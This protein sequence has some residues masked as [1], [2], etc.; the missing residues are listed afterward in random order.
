MQLRKSDKERMCIKSGFHLNIGFD[1]V[2]HFIANIIWRW[3]FCL[4][5][6]A[7]SI[8]NFVQIWNKNYQSG[9]IFIEKK[10]R[11]I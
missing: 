6:T 11:K 5:L 10:C 9:H 3:K 8:E 2:H 1:Y 7:C 4:N